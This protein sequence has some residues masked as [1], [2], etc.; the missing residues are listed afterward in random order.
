VDA[1]CKNVP[2][3]VRKA[4]SS[5]AAVEAEAV[6][7]LE[8]ECKHSYGL[9]L[10]GQHLLDNPPDSDHPLT[11]AEIRI[12]FQDSAEAYY[13]HLWAN[14]TLEEKLALADAARDRLA[15]PGSMRTVRQLLRKGLLVTRPHFGVMNRTFRSFISSEARLRELEQY[16]VAAAFY[17]GSKAFT[18]AAAFGGFGLVILLLLT[19]RDLLPSSVGVLTAIVGGLSALIRVLELARG[20]NRAQ[21]GESTP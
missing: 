13:E 14:L 1:A 9:Y 5:D 18:T 2:A 10:I 8:E 6:E 11:R 4:K 20:K 16:E 3:P 15:N 17:S 21:D 12:I 19:Q 7:F